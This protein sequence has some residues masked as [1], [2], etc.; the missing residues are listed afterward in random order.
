[1]VLDQVRLCRCVLGCYQVQGA[2][3]GVGWARTQGWVETAAALAPMTTES[4]LHSFITSSDSLPGA[5][6]PA[7]LREE[8]SGGP[9]MGECRK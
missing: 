9:R 6:A 1:M 7:W 8:R 3:A 5:T 4:L 2:Q